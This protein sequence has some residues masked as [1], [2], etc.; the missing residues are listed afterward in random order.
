M[1]RHWEQ[2][3]VSEDV[4][5]SVEKAL[6]LFLLDDSKKGK[7]QR[8]H[9]E[10]WNHFP[11]YLQSMHSRHRWPTRTGSSFITLLQDMDS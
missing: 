3:S 2:V 8:S 1:N 6:Q 11:L 7:I 4:K 5:I 10:Y 9:S